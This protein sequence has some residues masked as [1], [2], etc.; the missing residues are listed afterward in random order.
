M[1]TYSD[2]YEAAHGQ[3]LNF[4][5]FISDWLEEHEIFD[6]FQV[7]TI[8]DLINGVGWEFFNDELI[9][10]FESLPDLYKINDDETVTVYE[11]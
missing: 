5:D 7:D 2:I 8:I 4:N 1:S 11:N 9:S 6:G 10:Y 3:K